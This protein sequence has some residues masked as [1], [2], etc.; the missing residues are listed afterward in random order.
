MFET[1][2]EP[3][4]EAI[5]RAQDEA[6][7]MGH[8]MVG[9]E[10]LLLVLV[11]D[12]NSMASRVLAQ[13][14]LTIAPLRELVQERLDPGP[15]S[16]IRGQLRF[17]AEAKDALNSAH[18]FGLNGPAPRTCW[19]CSCAGVRAALVTFCARGR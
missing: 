12:Q 5:A 6:R 15:G 3:A 9:V 4:R 13:F 17:S 11:S 16:T 19:W 14:G 2:K 7:E 18:G 1:F 8:E 10:H